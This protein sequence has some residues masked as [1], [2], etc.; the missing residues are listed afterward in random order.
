MCLIKCPRIWERPQIQCAVDKLI[1]TKIEA[2]QKG[3][4]NKIESLEEEKREL[5]HSI[6]QL[7]N[8]E[9]NFGT[10]LDAV[11]S[12]IENPYGAWT[13]GDLKKKQLV[14]RLV[15]VN[16]I[17]IHPLEPIGTANLSL[18]FKMLRDVSEKNC[19][20]VEAAGI[21]PA[22]ASPLPLALHA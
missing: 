12:F 7:N 1:S 11:M 17:V 20:V 18:P 14:H 8:K 2:V 16:P 10:A 13:D 21:E 3:L 6:N 22:S 19:Q 9:I 5:E 15:F 4:E